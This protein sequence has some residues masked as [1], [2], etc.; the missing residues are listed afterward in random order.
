M[1][2][3]LLATLAIVA[4]LGWLVWSNRAELTRLDFTRLPT[5]GTWQLPTRVIESLGLEPGDRVADLGAGDGYFTFS[6]A[7]AVGP[8]G[9]VYAVEIDEHLVRG[10]RKQ[11]QLKDYAQVEVIHGE[12]DDPRLPDG[13][14]DLVFLCNTY[15][16]IES[17]TSYFAR[18]RADLRKGGRVAVIE[19]RDDLT[20]IAGL[21]A[22]RDHWMSRRTLIDEMELAGYRR[23][24]GFEYLPVQLFETFSQN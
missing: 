6:L 17:R 23:L 2:K 1:S 10:L 15:H 13:G 7:D 22:H 9:R 3:R 14:I 12:L 18:L 20:G 4:V 8:R 11:V 5:R 24:E 16:H 21:L 19:I